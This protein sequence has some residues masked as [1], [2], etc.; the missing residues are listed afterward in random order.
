MFGRYPRCMTR[1]QS[2]ASTSRKSVA[3]KGSKKV[4][5]R[6]TKKSAKKTSK[7]VTKKTVAK[8]KISGSVHA[9]PRSESV[10]AS[11]E[12]GTYRTKIDRLDQKLVDLLNDR[13]KLVVEVGELKRGS[14]TPI[15]A[16]HRE[17]QV[18]ERALERNDGPLPGRT[19]EGIYR[20]LMSGSFALEQP[21]RIG[22]LGP[23][24][25]YSHQASVKQFGSSVDYEDLQL[26]GGVFTE[27]RRGHVNY[28]LVPIENSIGGGITE[29][30]DALS[31]NAGH[32]WVY[33]E[34]QIAIRH[35]LLTNCK[36]HDVRRIHSKPEVFAQCRHWLNTQYPK[37]AL[38]PDASTSQSVMTAIKEN[39]TAIEIGAELGSAAIA[40]ELA[41][42]L[43]G[44]PVLFANIADNP[45]NITRFYVISREKAL[46]S[47]DDKTSI[48]FATEDK[49]GA[50]VEVLQAFH[51]EGI[52]L[53]HI[54]KRPSGRE[55][56]SYAFY[57]DALG[58][59]DDPA[60]K[61]AIKGAKAHCKDLHV[62][63][64]Y[65]RSKRIL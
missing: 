11:K 38:I 45:D 54:D 29:T 43:Y 61:K 34:V 22:F 19:I 37:A 65:P 56:W 7:K 44:L 24:G 13:A 63:G 47:G 62:L 57:I 53:S 12:L 28:G 31:K 8:K 14:D 30:L 18:L 49:S 16:P 5:Q 48:M 3:Q 26:I 9:E 21:L 40:S 55:N 6:S 33:A 20:E 36:P 58:H 23:L 4:A 32:V 42:E 64:S 46:R 10:A 50:L 52:N 15:Y 1:K 35:M 59:R 41:G 60:M 39:Q 27:V 2:K 51:N 25:S 17:A